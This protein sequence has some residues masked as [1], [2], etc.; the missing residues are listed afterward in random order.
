MQVTNMNRSFAIK[1][2]EENNYNAEA[3]YAIFQQ[4]QASNMIPPE[5]FTQ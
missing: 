2:L 1:C 3:A 5:A 4:L